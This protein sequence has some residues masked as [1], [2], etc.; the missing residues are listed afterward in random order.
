[1][2]NKRILSLVHLLFEL[3]LQLLLLK[4]Q[5]VTLLLKPDLW[6]CSCHKVDL[7][8]LDRLLRQ[9]AWLLV[10]INLFQ[11][12]G[13]LPDLPKRS[14]QLFVLDQLQMVPRLATSITGEAPQI[15][16]GDLICLLLAP[17]A[18]RLDHLLSS[19][20][21]GSQ[22]TWR[23]QAHLD[24]WSRLLQFFQLRDVTFWGFGQLGL[25]L[26]GWLGFSLR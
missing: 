9:N 10:R 14:D 8:C 12:V 23:Y 2:V 25:G 6:T 17:F 16:R 4:S 7:A 3:L 24:L 1:M 26:I 19:L 22:I 20:G 15:W 11:L 18:P 21:H 5:R 13:A